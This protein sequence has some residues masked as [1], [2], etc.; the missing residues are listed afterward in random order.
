MSDAAIHLAAST[1]ILREGAGLEVLMVRRNLAVEFAGGAMVFPGGRVD[2]G[3]LDPAWADCI[4]GWAEVPAI[5]RAPRI[6]ALREGFEESGILAGIKG[7]APQ[8]MPR[9]RQAMAAGELT[10]REALLR[11]GLRPDLRALTLFSR[12]M[13]PAILPKR[14]DTFFY[15]A[16]CPAGQLASSD[17]SETVA[18]EWITPAQA[19]EEAA[20]GRLHIVFP[21]RMNLR[22]LA[23]S[24]SV[25]A[26]ILAAQNRPAPRVTPE[27][28][29][30]G[31]ERY[32]RLGPES[33]FGEVRE[34]IG[35]L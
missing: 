11:L 5:E 25:E 19:I 9:L 15:L 8:D 28:E 16:V 1:L 10:F 29:G 3:D 35:R 31:P 34:K 32:L 14:F 26:A 22:R 17:G 27:V 21:T 7:P 6:A 12:W 18:A 30:H 2:A 13:T 23:E 24:Q 4:D 33:G 20:Q